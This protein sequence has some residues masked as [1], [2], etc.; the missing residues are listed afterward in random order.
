[1]KKA[2]WS[3]LVG[4]LA[5]FYFFPFEFSFFPGVNT[6]MMMA[7]LGIVVLAFYLIGSRKFELNINL[8]ILFVLASLVSLI[9]FFSIVYN[10][11]GDTSYV[12]YII[13][14]A[15]W[16]CSAFFLCMCIKEVHGKI[17]IPIITVY[18]AS[19]CVAQCC[20]AII[21]D[22]SPTFKTFVDT[23][24]LQ[25]Q[26][27]LNRVHRL[28]GIGASLDTAG[29]RFACCLVLLGYT[30]SKYKSSLGRVTSFFLVILFFVTF[31]MGNFIA[32]TTS[33]GAAVVIPY[34]VV[35]GWST[36]DSQK[37]KYLI[38][39]FFFV[40]VVAVVVSSALF[41]INDEAKNLIRFGFEGFVN[42]VEKGKW[43]IDSNETLKSMIV[44]PDNTKTWII[45]DGYFENPYSDDN[46][47]GD[48][49]ARGNFYMGTDIGYLRFIFYFG[50]VGLLAFA[51]Y[52]I[53]AAQT[54]A[55]YWKLDSW[56]AYLILILGFFIWLKVSTDVFFVFSLLICS[57]LLYT[58]SALD[59]DEFKR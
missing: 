56:L 40:F 45:G 27:F 58:Q 10:N 31:I 16:L 39:D 14:M 13:S 21:I 48:A 22:L 57:G 55:Y 20:L 51:I 12:G 11:T 44:F 53:H 4:I 1:M 41:R 29:G 15:V 8:L 49:P 32:R 5:S 33:I 19:V 6:K 30:L 46:Y 7:V 26:E 23:Y 38:K 54:A 43:E 25:G 50:I 9:G 3:L 36:R 34:M 17:T 42:L 18:F 52:L 35:S 37:N 47:I 59:P 24:V 28:Y 2:I